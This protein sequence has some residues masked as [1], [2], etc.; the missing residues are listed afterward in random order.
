MKKTLVSAALILFLISAVEAG[1]KFTYT[2]KSPEAV[3]VS[4]AGKKVAVMLVS[5]NRA[6]RAAAEEALAKEITKRGAEGIPAGSIVGESDLRDPAIAKEKFKE[7][8]VDGVVIIKGTPKG[9]ME[10]D[11]DMWKNPIYKDI[12]GFTSKSW[13]E[14]A[15]RKPAD[16][17]FVVKIAVYALEQ[18]RMI[19]LGTTEMKSSKLVEFVQGVVDEIAEEMQKEGLLIRNQ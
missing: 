17:K 16:V 10:Y 18:D 8:N 13:E 9:D 7:Q 11:P 6:P 12:W 15:G 19:W 3:P 1:I 2:W 5:T 14:E 4:F